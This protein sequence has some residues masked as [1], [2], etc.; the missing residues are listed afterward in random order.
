MIW[1]ISP[2]FILLFPTDRLF[3]IF[4]DIDFALYLYGVAKYFYNYLFHIYLS[5]FFHI[6]LLFCF[7]HF[8]QSWYYLA[9]LKHFN[10]WSEAPLAH[11]VQTRSYFWSVF[12][13]IRTEYSKIRTRNNLVFW[14]LSRSEGDARHF[15]NFH[16]SCVWSLLTSITSN[17]YLSFSTSQYS[18]F[19]VLKIG[20]ACQHL[21]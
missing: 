9:V 2:E 6:Y 4:F 16:F 19:E 10:I 12:S 7:K 15:G 8:I 13:C 11:F 18:L 5:V 20:Q 17:K 1:L 21:E 3:L 14:L